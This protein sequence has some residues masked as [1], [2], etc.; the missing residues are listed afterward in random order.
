LI[1]GRVTTLVDAGS[2]EPKH[3]EALERELNGDHLAQVVVTH[4]HTDHASGVT[5]LAAK[6]SP[7]RFL[8]MPWPERDERWPVAWEPLGDGSTVAAGDDTLTAVHTPGH[9]PDHLCFWH[10][11]SRTLFCG[12]LATKGTTVFIPPNQQGDLVDYLA[13]LERVLA[14]RP[15]RLL[16]AHGPVIDDPEAVLRG[17]IEHRQEREQ[18]IIGLLREGAIGPDA[19]VARLYRGLKDTLV[20]MARES[21]LAHLLKLEREGRAGRSAAS[22]PGASASA[23]RAAADRSAP[24]EGAARLQDA[25]HIIEP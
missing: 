20:P 1:R 17:Y 22:A 14:L 3:L 19:I 8:K 6:F 12:D 2:G 24:M 9:A 4:G 11:G 25:W 16:P 5:A 18:Q 21:V 10:A 15:A 23:P 7:V 13:S